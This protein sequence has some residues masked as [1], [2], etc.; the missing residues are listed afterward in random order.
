[1]LLVSFTLNLVQLLS[2]TC[3]LTCVDLDIGRV[4]SWVRR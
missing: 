1:M 4:V 3:E 2:S